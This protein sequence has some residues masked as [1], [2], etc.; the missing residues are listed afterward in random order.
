VDAVRVIGT[1]AFLLVFSVSGWALATDYRGFRR[2]QV[3]QSLHFA[4]PLRQI[5]PW[6]WF[7]LPSDEIMFQRQ[8]R[9]MRLTGWLFFL[10]GIF[11]TV[12]TLL[13][14]IF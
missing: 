11:L 9:Q 10:M 3:N 6:R 5:P 1:F 2:W 12:V 8:D 14:L 13:V 4:G 7:S